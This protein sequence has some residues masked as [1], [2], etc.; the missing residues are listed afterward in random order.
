MYGTA[1]PSP[2]Q[3]SSPAATAN[4]PLPKPHPHSMPHMSCMPETRARPECSGRPASSPN[5]VPTRGLSPG[6]REAARPPEPPSPPPPPPPLPSP[7]HQPAPPLRPLRRPRRQPPQRQW[8]RQGQLRPLQRAAW[9]P[10]AAARLRQGQLR[11]LQRAAWRPSAAARRGA[12]WRTALPHPRQ[13]QALPRLNPLL[14]P[15]RRLSQLRRRWLRPWR[16][17]QGPLLPEEAPSPEGHAPPVGV[18]LRIRVE[19]VLA[20]PGPAAPAAGPAP[21][22]T[23][24]AVTAG[25]PL[26]A[27][28]QAPP[29]GWHQASCTA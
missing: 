20:G 5:P 19:D 11:P 14:L 8:L 4:G 7:P 27:S 9:R 17:R 29:P 21:A 22:A 1:L 15:F 23:P 6:R 25:F 12:G 3:P 28:G 10:S 13:A 24:A 16:L 26:T 2:T 18:G